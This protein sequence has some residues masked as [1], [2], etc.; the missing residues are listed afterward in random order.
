VNEGYVRSTGIKAYND[1]SKV[2]APYPP[3]TGRHLWTFLGVWKVD[4]PAAS[5]QNFDMENLITVSGPGCFWC[6]QV[7]DPTMGS[8]CPGD[9]NDWSDPRVVVVKT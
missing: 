1:G 6:E 3:F 4:N 5:H 8:K 2:N 7:W 9:P